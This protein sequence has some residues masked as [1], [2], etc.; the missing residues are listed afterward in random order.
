M[1]LRTHSFVLELALKTSRQ[2]F[3]ERNPAPFRER[4]LDEAHAQTIR[5]AIRTYFEYEALLSR[6]RLRGRPIPEERQYYEKIA[7]IDLKI[8]LTE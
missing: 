3:N 5:E 4:D 7:K 6:S 8:S 2:L 1:F